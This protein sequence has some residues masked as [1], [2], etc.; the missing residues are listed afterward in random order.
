MDK[1]C[2]GLCRKNRDRTKGLKLRRINAYGGA[3]AE[4]EGVQS[5]LCT[6]SPSVLRQGAEVDKRVLVYF[7]YSNR[8]LT[9]GNCALGR[10]V[11]GYTNQHEWYIDGK[12]KIVHFI[13]ISKRQ[14]VTLPLLQIQLLLTSMALLLQRRRRRAAA[15]PQFAVAR[16]LRPPPLAVVGKIQL[17]KA[18]QFES[19]IQSRKNIGV[20]F[21]LCLKSKNFIFSVFLFDFFNGKNVLN[22]RHNCF[23]RS[24]NRIFHYRQVKICVQTICLR[25]SGKRQ[26]LTKLYR[27]FG[28]T[29]V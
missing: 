20:S 7:S 19:F 29:I 28:E 3:A 24:G 1:S 5:L 6:A 22:M 26:S 16:L 15:E 17:A 18:P 8:V 25:Y 2:V 14:P 27:F 13:I 23:L 9:T 11:Q 21:V 10:N 12:L 4:H